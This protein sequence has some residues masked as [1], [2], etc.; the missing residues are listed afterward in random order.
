MTKKRYAEL[1]K[2]E[3]AAFVTE[4][5]RLYTFGSACLIA[6]AISA[7]EDSKGW[8][9]VSLG[10][11]GDNIDI[12]LCDA[13]DLL[14]EGSKNALIRDMMT[15]PLNLLKTMHGQDLEKHI[16]HEAMHDAFCL[17]MAATSLLE[18]DF[19]GVEDVLTRMRGDNDNV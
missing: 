17:G 12:S 19:S 4:L 6:S 2:E 16:I 13:L 11:A 10:S 7:N 8:P 14:Y 3:E 1:T 15:S 9:F 5:S 18:L